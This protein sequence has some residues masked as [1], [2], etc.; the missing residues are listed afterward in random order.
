[1]GRYVRAVAEESLVWLNVSFILTA[2][3]CLLQRRLESEIEQIICGLQIDKRNS[4]CIRCN[5]NPVRYADPPLDDWN[6][7]IENRFFGISKTFGL[8]VNR[9]ESR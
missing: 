4:G 5:T 9:G 6:N 1:M 2:G 7:A 8:R 3:G